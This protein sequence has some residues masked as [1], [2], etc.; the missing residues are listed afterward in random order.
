MKKIILLIPIV[1]MSLFIHSCATAEELK[2]SPTTLHLDGAI[3]SLE[4]SVWRNFMPPAEPNGSPMIST[5]QLH[6]VS[7]TD[8]LT[9][10]HLVRQYIIYNN[11]VWAADLFDVGVN[12]SYIQGTSS[13]GPKWGPDATVDVVLEF[14]YQGNTYKI[15]RPDQPIEKVE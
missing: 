4:A 1:L 6:L 14:T 9:Q 10:L 11:E 7:G 3:L 12:G 2:A 8:I 5:I 13:G 15:Q